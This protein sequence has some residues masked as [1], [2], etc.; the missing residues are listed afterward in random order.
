MIEKRLC[1]LSK[2]EEVFSNI[3]GFYQNALNKGNFKY[4]LTYRQFNN[5]N[6][7]KNRKR[8]CYYYNFPF[9]NLY[10]QKLVNVS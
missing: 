1:K 7:K 4:N 5:I 6:I 9:V 2:N 3:K 10:S 8:N